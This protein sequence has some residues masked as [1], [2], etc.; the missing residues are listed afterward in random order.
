MALFSKRKVNKNRNSVECFYFQKHGH[1]T[2]NSKS[3][4]RDILNGKSRES[5]N[6]AIIE[7]LQEANLHDFSYCDNNNE[8]NIEPLLL[9]LKTIN[10][11]IY[12]VFMCVKKCQLHN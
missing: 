9:F 8:V 10:Y 3:R 1:T 5:A 6:I 11:I 4:A 7:D 12:N 2:F